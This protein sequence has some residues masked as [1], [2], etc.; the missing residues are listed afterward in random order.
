[1]TPRLLIAAEV[2][3]M[4]DG[5]EIYECP[6]QERIPT[7]ELGRYRSFREEPI[8]RIAWSSGSSR[9]LRI[10]ADARAGWEVR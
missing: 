7:V 2:A 3:S 10:G 6:R 1:M 8:E 9:V 4:L 5:A